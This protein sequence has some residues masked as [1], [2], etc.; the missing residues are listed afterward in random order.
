MAGKSTRIVSEPGPGGDELRIPLAIIE[1]A[2]DGPTLAIVAGV[3][4]SE[5]VGIQSTIKLAREI[6][7]G[8]LSGRIIIVHIA[9]I[10]AFFG[11]SMHICPIDGTNLGSVFPGDPGGGYTE[12]LAA[13]IWKHAAE[14][15]DY[16]IDVHGGDLEEILT[17]YV[18][19]PATGDARVEAESK[20]LADVFDAPLILRKQH[21]LDKPFVKGGLYDAAAEHGR[22]AI[23]TEAG[24]HGILDW[25]LVDHNHYHGFMNVL[26]HLHML[27]G[28][29]EMWRT[30]QQLKSFVGVRATQDGV[31][32]P[33]VE[34]GQTVQPGQVIGQLRDFFGDLI[35]KVESPVHAV[36]LGVITT[37]PMPE[38]GLMAGLGELV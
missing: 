6:D 20:A 16:L 9:N 15:A 35:M 25:T 29:P 24:S 21:P 19:W 23:L 7:P 5:Y 13:L 30:P 4:G 3:H 14:P 12:Q 28:E 8:Q 2:G 26:K 33:L 38:G 17:A 11:R 27:P 31:F 10:P 22:P 34:A 1:G 18:S 32:Y 37:P 36:V